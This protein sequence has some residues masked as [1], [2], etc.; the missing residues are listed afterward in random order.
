[1]HIAIE[2]QGAVKR[3]GRRR[4]LDGMSLLVPV[5]STMGLVGANG[6][7]KTTWMMATAGF[8]QLDAGEIKVWGQR[9]DAGEQSGVLSILPQD[10]ELPLDGRP[11]D[12]LTFYGELQGMRRRAAA[13]QAKELLEAVHLGDRV[14][15]KVR[16]LSHGMR[17]RVML[18]QCFMG[19]PKV[20]LLDE[21]LS[22]LD[23]RETAHIRG[24]INGFRGRRTFVI[25]SHV[26]TDIEVLCDRVTFM[27]AGKVTR[28]GLLE[29]V[30][31]ES[32]TLEEAYLKS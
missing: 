3:Y 15:S 5:N 10:S 7:G 1:M 14:G 29:D 26:L 9:F 17:K 28:T 31:G 8:T 6:A 30:V 20:V 13:V 23:P 4:A 27:E 18:A 19:E 2:T 22:G 12:L 25:S 16:Q 32:K 24:F 11:V 21:P